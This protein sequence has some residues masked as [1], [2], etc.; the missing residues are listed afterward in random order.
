[1]VWSRGGLGRLEQDFGDSHF[2]S[3]KMSDPTHLQVFTNSKT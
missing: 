2:D 3:L 1:M